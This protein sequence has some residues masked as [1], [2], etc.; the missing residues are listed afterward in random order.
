MNDGSVMEINTSEAMYNEDGTFRPFV[1]HHGNISGE[2]A[3]HRNTYMEAEREYFSQLLEDEGVRD[4]MKGLLVNYNAD[5]IFDE[6]MA[7]QEQLEYG[8]L[9]SREELEK[10][11]SM[12]PEEREAF[13]MRR[14]EQAEGLMCLLFASVRDKA[15]I[16]DEITLWEERFAQMENSNGRGL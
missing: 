6:A 9:E 2:I 14:L 7:I 15:L 10:M 8:Q 11:K 13:H 16:L 4:Y 1:G 3:D 5:H 12:T